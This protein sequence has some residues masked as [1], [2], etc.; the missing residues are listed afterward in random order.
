MSRLYAYLNAAFAAVILLLTGSCSEK[1]PVQ[2]ERGRISVSIASG[3]IITRSLSDDIADG[4]AIK[5][6]GVTGE[7]DLVLA[8]ANSAGNLVAWWPDDYWGSMAAGFTSE[9]QT[10]N[11]DETKSTI[12]FTGP[13]RG[14]YTVFAVANT[15]GLDA[16]T[17]TALQ[18]ATTI[19]ALEALQLTVD[20]GEPNFGSTMPLTAR[21]TLSVNTWGNGQIDLNLLRPVAR[22]S[23]TFVNQ[24][25][26]AVDIHDCEVTFEDLNPSRGFLF[27]QEPD[28]VTGYD[29]DLTVNGANPLV[30]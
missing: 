29:R 20:S 11:T 6:D 14:S 2:T 16:S 9:C 12:Y 13:S 3:K 21:G 18:S 27:E 17:I 28:Y 26:S 7:P 8:I 19:T 10:D 23:L 25:D 15:A 1:E 30:F 24:T 22:I 5:V 4:S